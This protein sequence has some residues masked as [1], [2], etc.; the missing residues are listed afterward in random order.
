MEKLV[1]KTRA[2]DFV[3]AGQEMAKAQD[4]RNVSKLWYDQTLSYDDGMNLMAEQAQQADDHI[5]TLSEVKTVVHND[6][7]AVEIKGRPYIPTEF[8]LQRMSGWGNPHVSSWQLQTLAEPFDQK[9][10]GRG[11]GVTSVERDRQD[12]E[13]VKAIVDNGFRRLDQDKKF[14]WRTWQNGTLRVMLSDSYQIVNNLWFMELIK[15]I[16]PGGRMSHWRGDADNIYGNVLIPD[17]I[18]E[19]SDSEYGGMIS[20]S[21]SEI[22]QRR[23]GSRPSIF[24]AICM[25]GCI[26]DQEKGESVSILHRGKGAVLETLKA[27]IEQNLH[28]QIPLLPSGIQRL[29]GTKAMGVDGPIEPVLAQVCMDEKLTPSLGKLVWAAYQVEQATNKENVRNLFGVVNSFTRAGQEIDN[30]GWVRFDEIGGRLTQYTPD[31]FA[32]VVKRAQTLQA[33]KVDEALGFAKV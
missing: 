22:G 28:A 14:L 5:L 20:V 27:T 10:K 3:H 6:K 33:E 8:C 31:R 21:N 15:S 1:G 19:E 2:G 30:A 32:A 13:L 16:V 11:A 24:R 18:R 17:S 23:I 7:F 29:L 25:N 12:A 26:W 4:F 9:N